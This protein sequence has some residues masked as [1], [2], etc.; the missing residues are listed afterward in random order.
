M[1]IINTLLILFIILII[2][3][4]LTDGKILI[5]LTQLFNNITNNFSEFINKKNIK[6]NINR[7]SRESFDTILKKL[8]VPSNKPS[9]NMN[10]NIASKNMI[11]ILEK[12]LLKLLNNHFNKYNYKFFNLIINNTVEYNVTNE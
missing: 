5:T 12:K 3:N 10:M 2:I 8:I 11:K 4:N 6:Q 7:E 1:N 9:N